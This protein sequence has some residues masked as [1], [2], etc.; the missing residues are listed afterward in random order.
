MNLS[1]RQP[2]KLRELGRQA[3]E[4]ERRHDA[5]R[6]ARTTQLD[7]IRTLQQRA[8][9]LPRERE[10]RLAAATSEAQHDALRKRID[11]DAKRIEGDLIA[12]RAELEHLQGQ[13]AEITAATSPL[14][15]LIGR[16]LAAANLHPA[17]AG[18][19]FGD[20]SPRHA[21]EPVAT[22]RGR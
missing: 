11:A 8:Q 14:R 15:E 22:I 21:G 18:I 16:I 2:A 12:A 10:V 20:D 1:H 17:D 3:H 4:L 6:A 19:D 9:R 7:Y 5:R 13:L